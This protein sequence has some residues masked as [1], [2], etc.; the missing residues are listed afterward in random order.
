MDQVLNMLTGEAP[1]QKYPSPSSSVSAEGETSSFLTPS[2]PA[3]QVLA[4]TGFIW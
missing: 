2:V 4:P 1:A 3:G